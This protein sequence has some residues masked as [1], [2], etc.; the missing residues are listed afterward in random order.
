MK[1]TDLLI[2]IYYQF[3]TSQKIRVRKLRWNTLIILNQKLEPSID[4]TEYQHNLIIIINSCFLVQYCDI[5]VENFLIIEKWQGRVDEKLIV[6]LYVLNFHLSQICFQ[7]YI[8]ARNNFPW[9]LLLCI[10]DLFDIFYPFT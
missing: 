2:F 5:C 10:G 3:Y 1:Y 4:Q 8:I 7:E 6:V 9:D